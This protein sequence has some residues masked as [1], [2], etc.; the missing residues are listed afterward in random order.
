MIAA[1]NGEAEDEDEK[2]INERRRK[3]Q[4]ILAKHQLSGNFG[5][6][7]LT[8]IECFCSLPKKALAD[9]RKRW[10]SSDIIKHCI[11]LWLAPGLG[12]LGSDNNL[13]A[14]KRCLLCLSQPTQHRVFCW[15]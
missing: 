2:L 15:Y 5:R 8:Y 10:V 11:C 3:R 12:W 9:I 14:L 1:L 7:A 6:L 13:H 4:E